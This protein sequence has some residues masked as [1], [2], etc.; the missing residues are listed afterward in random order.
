MDFNLSEIK[1][2]SM[3]WMFGAKNLL[4]L[5]SKLIYVGKNAG[6]NEA[7]KMFKKN[8]KDH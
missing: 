4:M 8:I 5:R 1:S 7:E 3:N 6:R 2:F